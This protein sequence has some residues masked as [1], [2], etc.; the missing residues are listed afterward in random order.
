MEEKKKKKDGKP[1][2][3]GIEWG[4]VCTSV[5][6]FL[7]GIVFF[8]FPDQSLRTVCYFFGAVT[9]LYGLV[10]ILTYF[11][12]KEQGLFFQMNIVIG[13]IFAGI[14]IFLLLTPEVVISIIPFIVGFFILFHSI[15]KIQQAMELRRIAYDKWWSMLILSVITALLGG[16]VIFN[17]FK[18]VTV[19]VRTIGI[20]LIADGIMNL[21]SI[22]F[23]A[24]TVKQRTKIIDE[25][26]GVGEE[27]ETDVIDNGNCD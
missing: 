2:E 3:K 5:L 13:I 19:M 14:G 12:R 20:V 7:L 25:A 6:Y 10:R 11:I 16:F 22:L 9:L 21:S 1:K 18:T 15:V 27:V 4:L 23:T 26:T 17:P 24:H 8:R